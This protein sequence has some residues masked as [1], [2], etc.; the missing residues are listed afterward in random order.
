MFAEIF[1]ELG[2]IGNLALVDDLLNRRY[3]QSIATKDRSVTYSLMLTGRKI[4][5]P[6]VIREKLFFEANK[7]NKLWV[8]QKRP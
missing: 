3:H 2:Q 7:S 8:R 5:S 1:W 6:Q 4:L